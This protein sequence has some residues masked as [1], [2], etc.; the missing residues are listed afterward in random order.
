MWSNRI[1]FDLQRGQI[2]GGN[3]LLVAGMPDGG[4]KMLEL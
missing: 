3:D 1:N 2:E 4:V